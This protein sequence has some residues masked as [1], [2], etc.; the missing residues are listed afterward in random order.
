MMK[1]DITN[2]TLS[3]NE[4]ALYIGVSTDLIYELVR[5]KKIPHFR[6]GQRILFRKA[7][8]DTWIVEQEAACSQMA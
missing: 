2:V 7:S 6:V 8:V 4:A 5:K 3:V 1:Q